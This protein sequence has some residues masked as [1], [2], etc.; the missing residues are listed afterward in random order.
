MMGENAG[1]DNW[2]WEVIV[3]WK[4]LEIYEDDPNADS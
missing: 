1:K 2:N 4:L 3:Q